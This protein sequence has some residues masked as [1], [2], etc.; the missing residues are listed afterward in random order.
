MKSLE[1]PKDFKYPL[2]YK[3]TFDVKV[4]SIRSPSQIQLKYQSTTIDIFDQ[5]DT[6]LNSVKAEVE[7]LRTS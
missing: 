6:S 5:Q 4:I 3:Y 2:G 1:F 7:S